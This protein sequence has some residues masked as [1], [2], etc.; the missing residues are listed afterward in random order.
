MLNVLLIDFLIFC[1]CCLDGHR[2][3]L[4]TNNKIGKPPEV[5]CT[6]NNVFSEEQRE[7]L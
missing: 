6:D 5:S 3:F 4:L 2:T 7:A 1:I